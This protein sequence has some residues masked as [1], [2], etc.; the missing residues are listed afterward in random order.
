MVSA[1]ISLVI[2]G[3]SLA[4]AVPIVLPV[5]GLALGATSLVREAK[6]EVRKKAV[7][8][9][10]IIGIVVNGFVTLMFLLGG[11]LR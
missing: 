5:I 9:L 2:G 6:K 1:I 3:L 10:A 7:K 8:V 4:G 11:F